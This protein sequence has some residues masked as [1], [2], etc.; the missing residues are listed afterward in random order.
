MIKVKV[1][2]T[3]PPCAKCKETEKRAKNVANK[4]PGKV[5]VTKFDALSDEGDKYDIMITPTVVINERVIA[6]GKL[7][8]EGELEKSIKKELMVAYPDAEHGFYA[9]LYPTSNNNFVMAVSPDIPDNELSNIIAHEIS[10]ILLMKMWDALIDGCDK[11]ALNQLET[12]CDAIAN[13]V[14]KKKKD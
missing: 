10:H 5:E 4:Y 9:C 2:G 1:F 13:A 11:V 7:I 3:T 12:V 8:S 6:A 14:T